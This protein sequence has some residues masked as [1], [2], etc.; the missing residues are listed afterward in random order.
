MLSEAVTQGSWIIFE[1]CHIATDWMMRLESLYTNLMKTKEINGDFRIWLV[2]KPAKTFPLI[3]LRDAIKIVTERPTNLRDSMIEQY[4]TEPL[5]SDKF[6]NS[7]FQAPLASVWYRFVFAFNAFHTVCLERMAY[8]SIGWSQTYDFYDNIRKLSLFQLRSFIKQCASIPYEQF[9]YLAND[10]IYGNEIIDICDRRLLSNL[11]QQFCNENTT[12]KNQY[13]FFELATLC[14]PSEPNRENTIEYLKTLP[15]RCA[16]CEFGL[17][18]NVHYLRSVN[19]SKSVSWIHLICTWH[20]YCMKMSSI[21]FGLL[22][23]FS[24]FSSC[25]LFTQHKSNTSHYWLNRIQI[26]LSTNRWNVYA[27]TF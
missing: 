27:M 20:I 25:K 19:E 16:P 8:G 22:W 21:S 5:S 26:K 15:L 10:C 6:F 11:L 14:I 13:V 24:V 12:T 3:I 7:A 17:H 4:S 1:N 9:L 23:G 18:N 2:L